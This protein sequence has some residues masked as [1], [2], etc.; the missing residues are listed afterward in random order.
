MELLRKIAR[1][2]ATSFKD[3]ADDVWDELGDTSMAPEGFRKTSRSS[4]KYALTA[5][6]LMTMNFPDDAEIFRSSFNV[7]NAGPTGSHGF[8]GTPVAHLLDAVADISQE[9]NAA[10][11]GTVGFSD[12][13]Q[14]STINDLGKLLPIIRSMAKEKK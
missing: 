1:Q 6:L 11:I 8:K 13:T 5:Q 10:A 12:V 9:R 4:G 2:T 14:T 3:I 7:T